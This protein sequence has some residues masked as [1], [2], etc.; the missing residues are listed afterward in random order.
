MIVNGEEGF[1]V[2]DVQ[3]EG[4][5]S[6][7]TSSLACYFLRFVSCPPYLLTIASCGANVFNQHK[8]MSAIGGRGHES[9]VPV[10][11]CGGI[12]F[13]M[14]GKRTYPDHIGNL[15]R[16]P[17]GVQKQ[18]CT[19]ATALPVAMHG[20]ARQN[21]QRYR[22]TRHPFD[23]AL[24][25]VGVPNFARDNRV[26]ADNRLATY[27]DIG[28]RRARLLGLQG[29]TNEESVKFRLAAGKFFNGVSSI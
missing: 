14:N 24:R 3:P 16:A 6:N 5:Y 9:E 25:C 7:R 22:M 20:Q 18:T 11:R 12:V 17:Q 8:K 21:E 15:Q 27:T 29:M 1:I 19:D 26:V 4:V 10:K 2:V 13:R 23:N 28:L